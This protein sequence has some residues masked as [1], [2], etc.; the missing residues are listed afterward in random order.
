MTGSGARRT[1]RA[2]AF[3][4]AGEQCRD[5]RGPPVP[6]I[7]RGGEAPETLRRATVFDPEVAFRRTVLQE[8]PV[9]LDSIHRFDGIIILLLCG[10]GRSRNDPL[11]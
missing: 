10:C 11:C 7:R 8:N 2:H 9:L 6:G 5:V 3:G 4:W 1:F